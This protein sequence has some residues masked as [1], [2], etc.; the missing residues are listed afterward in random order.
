MA[1][2]NIPEVRIARLEAELEAERKRSAELD[3]AFK[4]QLDANR[5]LIVENA[6]LKADLCHLKGTTVAG[7]ERNLQEAKDALSQERAKLE[8]YLKNE[9]RSARNRETNAV[10]GASNGVKLEMM[11]R[12]NNQADDDVPT[13]EIPR[14]NVSNLVQ[15]INAKSDTAGPSAPNADGDRPQRR[16]MKQ[17]NIAETYVT[18]N[19]RA[20]ENPHDDDPFDPDERPTGTTKLLSIRAV[21]PAA[22]LSAQRQL[23]KRPIRSGQKPVPTGRRGNPKAAPNS[24]PSERPKAMRKLAPKKQARTKSRSTATKEL[25]AHP[26]CKN[27]Y[28]NEKIVPEGEEIV[29]IEC[30]RRSKWYHCVCVLGCNKTPRSANKFVCKTGGCV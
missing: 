4:N 19:E 6:T 5:V 8:K 23:S 1:A 3:Q 28:D 24:S 25:C 21:K 10:L 20:Q 9:A 17:E 18:A 11:D 30:D 22:P 15:A 12:E 2:R 14:T 7:L 16:W 27:P 29:W 26:K 13:A